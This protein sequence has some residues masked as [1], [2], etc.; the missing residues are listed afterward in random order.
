MLAFLN[1][2]GGE[3]YLGLSDD[4]TVYGIT[5]DTDLEARK[6]TTSFRDS[7]TPDPSGYLKI[8]PEK[9]DEKYILKI[10]V[11]RGSSIPYSFS[12]YGLVP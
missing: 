7:V 12:K 11:E 1:T 6:V 4:G 10:T 5:G 8:E 3:L 9:R 2:E